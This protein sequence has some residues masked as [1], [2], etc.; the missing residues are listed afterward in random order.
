M[1]VRIMTAVWAADL[2]ATEKLVL[3][4][5][6]DQA[7]DDGHC[8]PSAMTIAKK[9]GQGERTVR[10]AIQ[11]LIAKKHLSQKMRS[12]TSA[13]YT[14]H[15]CQSGTPASPAPLPDT[16]DTPAAAAPKPSGT[17]IDE[18]WEVRAREIRTS[19]EWKAFAAMRR[20]IRKPLNPTAENRIFIK[21]RALAEAGYPPGAVLE[22]STANCW[23]G[24]FRIDEEDDSDRRQPQRT[25]GV[26]RHQPSDGRSATTR[27]AER[28][29]GSSFGPSDERRVPQ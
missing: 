9:C 8:W 16:P 19:P 6:A 5:L 14:V 28:V 21:L 11:S 2:P 3:L 25:N 26:G 17:T 10:R 29:F 27:A 18:E 24:V 13:V 4:A 20:Q 12:G 22:Q 23:R 15:P 7:N 1:S